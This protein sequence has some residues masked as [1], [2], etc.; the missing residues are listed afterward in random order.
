MQEWYLGWEKV[1]S[2]QEC[3]HKERGST[4]L[5]VY[6]LVCVSKPHLLPRP[7]GGGGSYVSCDGREGSGSVQPIQQ[8]QRE[9]QGA[10]WQRRR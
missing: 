2:V 10:E 5:Y 4:C 9:I 1:S 3:P 7:G 6:Y 8:G